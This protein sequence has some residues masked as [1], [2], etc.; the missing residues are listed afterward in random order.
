MIPFT[1]ICMKAMKNNHP[2]RESGKGYHRTIFIP[3]VIAVLLLIHNHVFAQEAKDSTTLSD[4]QAGKPS[5]TMNLN[6]LAS[7]GVRTVKVQLSR[8]EKKKTIVVN[9]VKSPFNLYLN[10]VK[11]YD[12]SDGTGLIGKL[13]INY[14][15]E[16]VFVLPVEFYKVSA[17]LHQYTFIVKMESDPKYEDKE[18]TIIVADAKISMVF[19]GEDSVKGATATL[20]AWKDSAGAY[21]PVS[22]KELKLCI[23]RTFNFLIFGEAGT[24]T[25]ETGQVS[26]DLPMDLPGNR[27]STL[28]L[29]GLLEDDETYGT[30]EGGITVP[31]AVL[32]KKNA[33]RGRTLWSSG[34][35]A[36]L[37]LVISSLLIITIIWG[38]IFYLV[39]L[40]FR[41]KK[42]GKSP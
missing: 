36:P 23:K 16:G 1:N 35:N 5:F 33:V 38:T 11:A 20:T 39:R 3:F 8:K 30:V 41:I 17:S 10:E 32:P 26:G 34:D 14:E 42:L 29:F 40:L 15:G 19:A 28:T 6:S 21:I 37:I 25:D 31:W 24:L 13:N 22:E 7:N 2:Y 12:A 9:D 27:D 4:S 18:E